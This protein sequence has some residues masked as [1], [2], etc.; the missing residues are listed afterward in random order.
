MFYRYATTRYIADGIGNF[1]V[2]GIY[3]FLYHTQNYR[4]ETEEFRLD[5]GVFVLKYCLMWGGGG[6]STHTGKE[7]PHPG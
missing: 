6:V 1:Q 2:N 4:E 3:N 7:T 5:L